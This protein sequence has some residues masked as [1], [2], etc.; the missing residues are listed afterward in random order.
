ME[1]PWLG[2]CSKDRT[3]GGVRGTQQTDGRTGPMGQL[4][5]DTHLHVQ[6]GWPFRHPGRS[7]VITQLCANLIPP[8]KA[9]FLSASSSGQTSLRP[10][11]HPLPVRSCQVRGRAGN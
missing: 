6:A 10:R 3:L 1:E 4:T 9:P 8:S 5:E 7:R 11:I 2:E